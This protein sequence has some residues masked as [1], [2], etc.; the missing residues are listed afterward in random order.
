MMSLLDEVGRFEVRTWP[1]R[2]RVVVELRGDLDIAG[3]GAVR[4][5]LDDLHAAGWDTIV[6]DLR[7]LRFI[8]ST[9]LSLLL[10]ADRAARRRGAV[11]AIVDGSPAVARLLELVGLSDHFARAEV[12]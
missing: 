3:A 11:L 9:G 12:R 7:G 8:D 5:V 2:A 6:M 1:D 10:E 4:E